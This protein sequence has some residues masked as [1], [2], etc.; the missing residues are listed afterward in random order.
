VLDG[1]GEA[2]EVELRGYSAEQAARELAMFGS[3]IEIIEPN[4]VREAL[5]A[6]G[7]DLVRTHSYQA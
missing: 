2:I 4:E 7:A 1:S 3:M 6:L 5:A